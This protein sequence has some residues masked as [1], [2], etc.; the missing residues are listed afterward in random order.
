M[1]RA[2]FYLRLFPGTEN[3]FDRRAAEISVAVADA[4]RRSGVGGLTLFRRGTDAWAYAECEPDADTA[5]AA[6]LAEPTIAAWHESLATVVAEMTGPDG[7]LLAY[8]E[9][10]HSN[11]GGTGPFERGMF[12]L[13][14]APERTAEYDARHAD[15]WP[16][17]MAALGE[18]GFHN[19]SGFRRAS[20]VV[21]YGEFYPDMATAVATIG[22]TD[23]NRRWTES[24]D[25]IITTITDE[26]EKLVTPREV[27]HL[28]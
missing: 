21:Y 5:L 15:P 2:C 20:H 22:V 24:F 13:V 14:V 6:Y 25:G 12:G 7:R 28:D 1:E 10:F 4:V 8:D 17:M 23:V 19:Y 11:G 26:Q 16:E 3:E 18:S 27:L 9:V